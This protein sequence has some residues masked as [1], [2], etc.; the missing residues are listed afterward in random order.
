MRAKNA[1]TPKKHRGTKH[2]ELKYRCSKFMF[3]LERR[4]TCLP[5][6]M[7]K[8]SHSVRSPLAFFHFAYKN[9]TESATD[10][11]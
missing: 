2:R 3:P 11:S 7:P 4:R 6:D 10:S 5:D 9:N 1:M 8:P